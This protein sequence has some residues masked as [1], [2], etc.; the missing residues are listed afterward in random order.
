MIISIKKPVFI[1]LDK[2][3]NELYI[4]PLNNTACSRDTAYS[5]YESLKNDAKAKVYKK[6]L[7]NYSSIKPEGST[8]QT[9]ENTKE[10]IVTT[11]KSHETTNKLKQNNHLK[12][13]VCFGNKCQQLPLK[14]EELLKELPYIPFIKQ[15][16]RTLFIW[17]KKLED[18]LNEEEDLGADLGSGSN[19]NSRHKNKKKKFSL[20]A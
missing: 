16:R 17:F 18:Q 15:A 11:R 2:N 14:Q 8:I 7:S 12:S 20:L 6:E 3:G 4:N 5:A 1:G 10:F 13:K 9:I 19:S